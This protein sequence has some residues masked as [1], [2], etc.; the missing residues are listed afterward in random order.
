MELCFSF[1]FDFVGWFALSFLTPELSNLN[2]RLHKIGGSGRSKYTESPKL[3]QGEIN[4]R[5][6]WCNNQLHN[7]K[8]NPSNAVLSYERKTK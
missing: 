8:F 2:I 3:K 5:V 6:E 1:C 7:L 4:K